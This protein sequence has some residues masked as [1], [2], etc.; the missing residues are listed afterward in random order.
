MPEPKPLP[1]VRMSGFKAID[2]REPAIGHLHG[3]RLVDDEERAV[4]ARERGAR[5]RGSPDREGPD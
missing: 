1:V 3:V 5:Q 2:A 4:L